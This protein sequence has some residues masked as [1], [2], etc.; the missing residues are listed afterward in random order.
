MVLVASAIKDLS[1]KVALGRTVIR[2]LCG[3]AKTSR[4]SKNIRLVFIKKFGFVMVL[5]C[6]V[7]TFAT[8]R[9]L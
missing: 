1:I 7:G 8:W 4:D 9:K 3:H 5:G 2:R 6:Y